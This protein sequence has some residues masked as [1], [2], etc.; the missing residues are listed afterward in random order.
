M[1]KSIL[2]TFLLVSVLAV[3]CSMNNKNPKT[4][5]IVQQATNN[6][7]KLTNASFKDVENAFGTP[8]SAVYYINADNLKGKDIN[9]LTME[10]IRNNVTVLSTYE[11]AKE[12]NSYLHVYYENGKVKNTLAGAYDLSTSEKLTNNANLSNANYKVEFFKNKGTLCYDDFNL[13]TAKDKFVGKKIEEFNK[14]YQVESS[15]FIASTTKGT[16]KIYFYPLVPHNI[17]PSKEHK[18]PNYASN[19][20]AKL[21][22]VNPI[23]NNISITNNTD[24]KNL[25]EYA[26]SAVVVYTKDDKIQT[27][28]T[29]DGNFIYGLIEKSFATK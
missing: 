9:N 28:E 6:M 23:N 13:N 1:K 18:Y 14:A 25:A 4:E 11:N 22:T 2:F 27:I 19:E 7:E 20:D 17:H 15:N 16:D 8:Y 26:E 29:V 21:D 24:N 5:N 12:P 3:G 10:D